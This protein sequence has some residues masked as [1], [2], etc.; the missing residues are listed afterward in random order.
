MKPRLS[1]NDVV[2]SISK[3][4]LA[5]TLNRK[6]VKVGETSVSKFQELIDTVNILLS[7][8]LS[9]IIIFVNIHA[10]D[11]TIYD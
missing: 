1:L 11:V 8:R 2:I 7:L 3:Q 6:N 5:E 4:A 9:F 10:N